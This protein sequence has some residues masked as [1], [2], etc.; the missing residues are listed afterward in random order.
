MPFHGPSSGFSASQRS[1]ANGVLVSELLL[2][3]SVPL[4]SWTSD[5]FC[6]PEPFV[7]VVDQARWSLAALWCCLVGFDM[8]TG[9]LRDARVRLAKSLMVSSNAEKD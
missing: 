4:L 3:L 2:L 1:I 5:R 8:L 9:L 7:A 6:S